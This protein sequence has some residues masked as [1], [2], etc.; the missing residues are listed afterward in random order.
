[1]MPEAEAEAQFSGELAAQF[2]PTGTRDAKI[3]WPYGVSVSEGRCFVFDGSGWTKW[4]MWEMH[5]MDPPMRGQKWPGN[6]SSL[7]AQNIAD[8]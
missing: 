8:E 5:C 7:L 1:M 6:T 3:T 2:D 4:E